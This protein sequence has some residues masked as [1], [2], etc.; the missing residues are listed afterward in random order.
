MTK[1][2][3]RRYSGQRLTKKIVGVVGVVIYLRR[4]YNI[5]AAS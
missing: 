5:T 2:G 3:K 1:E 4:E